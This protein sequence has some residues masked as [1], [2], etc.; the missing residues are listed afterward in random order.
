[1]GCGM[2]GFTVVDMARDALTVLD[3]EGV[4]TAHMVGLSL[5]GCVAQEFALSYPER[6]DKLVLMG[7]FPSSKDYMEATAEMWKDILDVRGLSAEE[8]VASG[9]QAAVTPG[10]FKQRAD[11]VAELVRIRLEHP[12]GAMG[13]MNQYRAGGTHEAKERLGSLRCPTLVMVGEQDRMVPPRFSREMAKL[14]P[15]AVYHEIAGSGH[16]PI[17]EFPEET[18][19]LL[20]DHLLS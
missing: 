20:L 8:S 4:Q 3:A 16:L 10:F 1:M 13:F 12:Q 7:T 15:G 14:I 17:Y 19:R 9:I 6:V 5:G 18:N 11:I 2:Y